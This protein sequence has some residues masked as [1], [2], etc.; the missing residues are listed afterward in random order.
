MYKT[1]FDFNLYHT[2]FLD[3]GEKTFFQTNGATRLAEEDR[4]TVEKKY[5]L[6]D[7]LGIVPTM[8][9]V[10]KLKNHRLFIR[11][12]AKGFRVL[13]ETNKQIALE[14]GMEVSR[15]SPVIPLDDSLNL[16]FYLKVHDPY[17]Y[18][19]SSIVE[20]KISQ[21]YLLTNR[22]SSGINIFRATSKERKWKRFLINEKETRQ[23]VYNLEV[24][25]QKQLRVPNLVSIDVIQPDELNAI[26]MKIENAQSLTDAEQEVINTL[27]TA[28]KILK[29]RGIVGVLQLQ[30]KGDD[31][32][33]FTESINVKNPNNQQFDLEK[34]CLPKVYPDFEVFINN[35]ET[36]WRYKELQTSTIMTTTQKKPL[37]KNGRVE[38]EN[39]DVLPQPQGDYFF[40]NPTPEIIIKEAQK[41]YSEV[42]I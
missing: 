25:N 21:L 5:E 33:E 7:F 29:N 36:F 15:Y 11:N 31:N 16:T 34:Q 8:S 37:T 26:E 12:H 38:I 13:S 14:G 10:Q 17:F 30:I 19:Y 39:Q 6:E 42:F 23:L 27:N 18:N 32:T 28:V 35:R 3:E 4:E 40:P 22:D 1:L 24:E 9:T 20:K 2:Y 41:Y